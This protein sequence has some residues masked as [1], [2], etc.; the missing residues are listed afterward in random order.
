[1]RIIP[2]S[3]LQSMFALE[4]EEFPL[5]L[6]TL[7]RPGQIIRLS[8]DPTQRISEDPIAYGTPS[9]GE[10]FVYFPFELTLPQDQAESVPRMNIRVENVS[11]EIGW[12]LRSSTV[13][14][15]ATVE[16]I[17]SGDLDNPIAVFPDFDL[18]S[19]RGGTMMV[20]GNFVLS[21][22]EN[23]PYPAGTFNP[24]YFPGLF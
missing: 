9:R 6:L 21:N 7:S 5:I 10:T 23:E 16:I 13:K 18:A 4:A 1:M 2:L 15:A 14:P 12:W 17:S 20:E 24:G 22:L 3:A 19:F 11:A 8:S